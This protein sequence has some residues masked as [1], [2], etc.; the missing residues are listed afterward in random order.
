[1]ISDTM[2]PH[3]QGLSEIGK[4][5][6]AFART[7]RVTL[8][9]DGVTPES[10]TDH[11]VMLSV[12]ACALA[13]KLYPDS[14]DRGLI[15]QF[16]I[17]HDLVEALVGDTSTFNISPEDRRLKEERE[18]SAFLRIEEQ[19][20]DVYPW[21]PRTIEAY[22]SQ[23]T[24]EARFVK[25]VDKVMTKLTH[26]LNKGAYMRNNHT[27]MAETR[28]HFTSQFVELKEKYG[29]EFPEII[30]ILQEF[31]EAVFTG[32]YNEALS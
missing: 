4:L 23:R 16:A 6:F 3:A 12:S 26:A 25:L 14:L 7:N 8:H 15:A 21:I 5:I 17:V 19:F 27:L 28:T 29:T 24:P 31:T 10:D 30:Q 20:I 13:Q 2:T 1:M 18:H 9:D 22:E 32:L 11:T